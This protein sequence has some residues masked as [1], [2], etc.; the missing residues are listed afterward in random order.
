MPH[1][2]SGVSV[3]VKNSTWITVQWIKPDVKTEPTFYTATAIDYITKTNTSSCT[4]NG[5][6]STTC[7]IE[8]LDEYWPYTIVVIATTVS[9][10]T[11]STDNKTV[12]TQEDAPGQVTGF[13]VNVE[14]D[15]TKP[16]TV[17]VTCNPPTERDLN[18]IIT[19]YTLVWG[20]PGG[21][22]NQRISRTCS[23]LQIAVEPQK[24]YTFTVWASTKP[25][26][27]KTTLTSEDIQA[28]AP[29]VVAESQQ[30]ILLGSASSVS[31]TEKQF[32]VD[33]DVSLVCDTRNGEITNRYVFVSEGRRG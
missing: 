9:G 29:L 16:R 12:R 19:N 30:M 3:P 28:G 13:R 22:Q 26:K 6:E 11:Y 1:P 25:G 32:R 14:S 10:S 23:W 15:V 5:F 4:T 18:G 21:T 20:Y 33:F 8:N 27:G 17:N 24:K 2:P 31:D 7:T